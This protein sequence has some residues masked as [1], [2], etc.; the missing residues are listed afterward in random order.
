MDSFQAQFGVLPAPVHGILVS[1]ILLCAAVGSSVAGR[2]AD[3]LGRPRAIAL[4]AAIFTIG[5]ALQAGAVH[6]VMFAIGRVVEG[7]GYGFYIGTQTVYICEIAPP[8]YRGPL[9][10]GPQ[11]MTC[12]G[13]VV[14]YFMSYGTVKIPGSLSWRLP[15]VVTAVIAAAYVLI[16]LFVLPDSPPWLVLQGRQTDADKVWDQLGVHRKDR[17]GHGEIPLVPTGAPPMSIEDP[18]QRA[19]DDKTVS[20]KDLWARDVRMRTFLA[21]FL[22]GFLQLCGIDA[23]LYVGVYLYSP[24]LF[25]Q[26]GLQS[27]EASF[28][29]SGVSAIVI[30]VTSIPATLFADRWGRRTSTL[31][32]GVGLTFSLMLIGTLYSANAVHSG[33]GAGRWV[34]VVTIYVYLVIQASTWAISIKVWAPEIQ[35]RRTRAQATNLAYV[36]NWC[37][38]FFVA[39]VCPILLDKSVPSAYFLFGGCTALATLVSY[40]YMVE[41]KGKSFNEIAKAF[42]KTE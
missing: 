42:N 5:V 16:N 6:L 15:F 33:S 1:C 10:S 35:P 36:F 18:V 25:Q 26:A 4:G 37:C 2:P 40:F 14:G 24:L 29:A 3:V 20:F 21:M 27:Q 11:F 13:L 39:F 41:T 28:L 12:L 7:F 9:T 19:R 17:E 8:K 23:V 30:V 32:G 31:V 38:N 34:V 22:L